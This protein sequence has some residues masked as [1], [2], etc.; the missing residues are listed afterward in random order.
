MCPHTFAIHFRRTYGTRVV[1]VRVPATEVVGYCQRSLQ[2]RG[3]LHS[4][5]Q[6]RWLPPQE[7]DAPT[8]ENFEMDGQI[9]LRILPDRFNQA[10][11]FYQHLVGVVV[12]GGIPQQLSD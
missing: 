9:P 12:E 2:K 4:V 5:R 3:L 11:S 7:R 6:G 10:A 1:S 8:L